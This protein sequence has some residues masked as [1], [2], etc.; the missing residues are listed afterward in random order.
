MP[1]PLTFSLHHDGMDSLFVSFWGRNKLTELAWMFEV[2]EL[3][4]IKVMGYRLR[5]KDNW[6]RERESY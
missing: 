1:F 2:K 5:N 6:S 3:V 4:T